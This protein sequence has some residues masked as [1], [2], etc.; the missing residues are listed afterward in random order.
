M[1]LE[2]ERERL[3]SKCKIVFKF[4]GECDM[5]A[6]AEET[7]TELFRERERGKVLVVKSTEA[8]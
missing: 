2:R 8:L 3:A 5:S 4:D 7:P 6:W 1:T